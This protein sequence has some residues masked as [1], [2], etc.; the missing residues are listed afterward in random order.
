MTNRTSLSWGFLGSV[1]L[2]AGIHACSAGDVSAPRTGGGTNTGAGGSTNGNGGGFGNGGSGNSPLGN[3]G[4]GNSPLGNGG[5][6]N[7]PLGNGGST[8]AGGGFGTGTGG[9]TGNGG[10]FG[11]GTGGAGA[12]TGGG[13][14]AGGTSGAGT[15][16]SVGAGGTTMTVDSNFAMNGFGMIATPAWQGY[17]YTSTYGAGTITPVCAQAPSPAA[18]CFSMSNAQLCVSGNVPPDPMG[19]N[20]ALLGWNINHPKTATVDGTLATTG[21]GVTLTVAG[22]IAGFRVQ[23]EDA[24]AT[25]TRWCFDLPATTGATVAIPWTSFRTNCYTPTDPTSVPYVVGTP[26]K[27]IQI[28]VPSQGAATPFNFCLVSVS[29]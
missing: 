22:S 15:G 23:I 7:S 17:L 21:T 12:G 10:G 3:G 20:G 19:A 9:T 11:A 6:G 16:G 5:S 29:G 8:S 26:I 2:L 1:A 14:G 24:A 27:D 25:P 28:V 13:F 18:P 4:S